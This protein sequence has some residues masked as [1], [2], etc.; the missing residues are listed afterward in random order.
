MIFYRATVCIAILSLLAAVR[1][2]AFADTP[3]NQQ[4]LNQK[5][6]NEA[7]Q[8]SLAT[9]SKSLLSSTSNK[10]E[11]GLNLPQEAPCYPVNAI[12]FENKN[13]VAHWMTFQDV[14]RSVR[15]K[16][17]GING[18]KMIHKAVQ[19]RLIEHGYITTRVLIPAQDLKSGTLK[20][21]ILPGTISDI[22]FKGDGG[23]YIHAINNF[24]E[25]EGDVLDLRGLEQGLENLQRTPGSEAT[26]N[27]VP[28]ANPGETRVEVM[29]TQPKHWRLGAWADDSGSKY[30]GRYQSGLALYL[31][32]L[33]SFNDM[34]YIAYG[35]GLKNEDGRRSDNVS[36]FY[37]V[38]WGYWQL[39][40]YGSKYRYTQTIHDSVSRYL[41]SGIEKYLSAQLSRVI[42]RSASQKTTLAIKVFRRHSTYLLNDVEIEVQ[43][44][45]TSNWKLSLEH[46]AYLPFGQIKGS[47][48]YQKAA[49]WFNEQE[50]AEEMVGNADAQA[51]IITI[52]VDGAFPFTLGTFSLSYEPHFMSQTSPD[53]LTQPDKFTIG[54]RWTVRGFDGETTIYADKGWYLRNDINL[55][56]PQWG[57]QPY[58]GVDYGEVKGSKN[59]Y[60]SGKH[61]AG[62]ALGVRGVK[63]KF[64]YDLFAGVPL[65]KPEE[66]HTSPVTLG[67]AMQWQY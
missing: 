1:S 31:D 51:R 20:F 15:G 38:P 63:G 4:S 46:L 34:F 29:R 16:C 18:L 6:Q 64:G 65:I 30:T 40:L 47:L 10:P 19:N 23:E 39:E 11:E 33:T 17:V 27:L 66:L 3:E 13:A 35:G 36:A 57:M 9:Q 58:L 43:R 25:R 61:L 37:S 59:D 14:M 44:R 2:Q 8:E 54:N 42:Y 22:V 7:R 62:A 53:R 56:L 67:F 21:Q 5:Q 45:K 60:W 32:N 55:N 26:I 49:H 24:P 52:G 28:G 50:D 48:G 12:E 41:Y